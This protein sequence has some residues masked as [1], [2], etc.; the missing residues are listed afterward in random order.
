MRN[1]LKSWVVWASILGAVGVIMQALGVFD[2]IGMTSEA[3][4][5][6]I[7]ALGTI[8]VTLGILNNPTDK[9]E[10]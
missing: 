1:R 2:K 7:T 10:F 5:N 3:W 6:V 8:L 9:N 4:Q